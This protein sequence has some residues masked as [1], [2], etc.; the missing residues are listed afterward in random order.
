[1]HVVTRSVMWLYNAVTITTE[2]QVL[3]WSE[4]FLESIRVLHVHYCSRYNVDVDVSLWSCGPCYK[5]VK[6]H[7]MDASGCVPSID[8][9]LYENHENHFRY[10]VSD[11]GIEIDSILAL[12]RCVKPTSH[13]FVILW[14]GLI[15]LSLV[16][17]WFTHLHVGIHT[18]YMYVH[19]FVSGVG[20]ERHECL[21][22][23]YISISCLQGCFLLVGVHKWISHLGPLG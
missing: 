3:W 21:A 7:S 23:R 19:Q 13:V 12:E 1:M 6:V 2:A 22:S 18:Q 20:V 4:W 8:G 14:L 5:S 9:F 17:I 15:Q 16:S 11:A 10:C